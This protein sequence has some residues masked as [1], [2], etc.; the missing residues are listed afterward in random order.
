MNVFRVLILELEIDERV[1]LIGPEERDQC[2]PS[3]P[4]SGLSLTVRALQQE[5]RFRALEDD[6]DQQH[7]RNE[8]REELHCGGVNGI[9]MPSS[10]RRDLR[11]GFLHGLAAEE[12]PRKAHEIED[13]ES[14]QQFSEERGRVRNFALAGKESLDRQPRSMDP[15]PNYEGPARA[16]PQSA[17]KHRQH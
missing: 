13:E 7:R 12:N 9:P 16:V 8:N 3:E 1:N 10:K 2:A 14:A 4:G 17:E 15:A 5:L 6:I 11:P